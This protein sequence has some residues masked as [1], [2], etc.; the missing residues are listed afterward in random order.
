AIL[1][2]L[3]SARAQQAKPSPSEAKPSFSVVNFQKLLPILPEPPAGWKADK[4]EG[5]TTESEGFSLTTAGRTYVQGEAENAPTV[6]LNILDSGNSKQF[7]DVTTAP[8]NVSKETTEGYMKAATID[9]NR[10]YEQF[11]K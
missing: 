9:G 4:P 2:A 5:S 6:T 7:Y 3:P 10:G 11:T 1:A 8:W